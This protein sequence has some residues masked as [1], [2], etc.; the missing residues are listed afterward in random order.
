MQKQQQRADGFVVQENA[1]LDGQALALAQE[2]FQLVRGGD[3]DRLRRLLDL[4]LPPNM[5][6]DKGDS[7]LMLASYHGHAGTS[8]LLLEK[9]ADPE[10]RN[11]RGHTPLAGAAFKGDVRMVEL[12]LAHG[13]AVDGRSADGKTPL[14]FAAMFDRPEVVD[15]LIA[16]GADVTARDDAGLDARALARAMGAARTS[17][18]LAAH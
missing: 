14:M 4:G 10:L 15:A 17:E 9:G 5:C 2:V 7:L 8:A 18:Q 11:D 13:A 6:N 12:L 3:T 1:V 16:A